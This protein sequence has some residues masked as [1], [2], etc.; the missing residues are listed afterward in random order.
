MTIYVMH[1]LSECTCRQEEAME[2]EEAKKLLKEFRKESER[3]VL[4]IEA[5]M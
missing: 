4:V 3:H 2:S 1:L 5:D